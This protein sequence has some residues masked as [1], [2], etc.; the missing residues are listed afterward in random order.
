MMLNIVEIKPLVSQTRTG[1]F[2]LNG[3][4][5]GGGNTNPF[6]GGITGVALRHRSAACQSRVPPKLLDWSPYRYEQALRRI[7]C[8]PSVHIH[9][10]SVAA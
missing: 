8:E 1:D 3:I 5:I 6:L 4:G 7:P 10:L 2:L 9:F